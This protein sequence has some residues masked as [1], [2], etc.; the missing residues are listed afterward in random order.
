MNKRFLLMG[1]AAVL[2]MATVVGSALGAGQASSEKPVVADLE[3][4]A[5]SIEWS[6]RQE[7]SE[8]VPVTVDTSGVMPGD[9]IELKDSQGNPGIYNVDNTGIKNPVDMMSTND[10]YDNYFSK[11]NTDVSDQLVLMLFNSAE[12]FD[13]QKVHDIWVADNGDDITNSITEWYNSWGSK[14]IYNEV[15]AR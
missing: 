4:A 1:A 13:L 5:F 3:A 8:T 14:D 7:T 11:A 2:V 12:A 9:T 15:K 6:D 10:A